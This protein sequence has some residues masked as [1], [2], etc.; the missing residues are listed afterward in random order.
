MT[1]RSFLGAAPLAAAVQRAVTVPVRIVSDKRMQAGSEAARRFWSEIWPQ[2]VNDFGSGGI[3]LK[4]TRVA[5]E[6][7]RSPSGKPV[8]VGLSK[9][10][11]NL[12]LSDQV[13]V[14]WDRGRGLAGVTTRH[15]AFH[16]CLIATRQA[17]A[18]RIPFIAVNT[19]VHE[20]LHALMLDIFESRPPGW[21][22]QARELMIDV[23]ATRLWLFGDGAAIRQS[24]QA[25]LDRLR[26]STN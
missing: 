25:Y 15:E 24:A 3:E 4:D 13:P 12:V 16:V 20:L 18:H 1:R 10:S 7:R 19:C 22:G 17:H 21:Y 11:I 6:V 14:A 5:G 23:Y 8:F 2:A 26:A 9:D